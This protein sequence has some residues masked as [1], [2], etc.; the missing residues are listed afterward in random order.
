MEVLEV[1]FHH[2]IQTPERV[3]IHY[4]DLKISLN[5]ENG[6]AMGPAGSSTQNKLGCFPSWVS[7][8][9]SMFSSK[10]KTSLNVQPKIAKSPHVHPIFSAP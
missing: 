7:K 3:K 6:E 10:T 5:I 1:L 8:S 2:T 9:P 4:T